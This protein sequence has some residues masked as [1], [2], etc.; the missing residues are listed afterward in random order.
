MAPLAKLMGMKVVV[1][2]RGLDYDKQKWGGFAK[3]ALKTG[4]Y[5]GVKYADSVIVITEV[6]NDIIKKRYNKYD[7]DKITAQNFSV[8]QNFSEKCLK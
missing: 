5:M 4:E 7:W 1:T 6:I 8:Y 3:F 2:H